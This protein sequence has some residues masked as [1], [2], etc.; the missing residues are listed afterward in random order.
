MIEAVACSGSGGDFLF[1][2]VADGG[3]LFVESDG[4]IVVA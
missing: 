2:V 4:A 1:F 3:F